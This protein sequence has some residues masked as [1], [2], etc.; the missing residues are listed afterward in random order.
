MTAI[1][2][3]KNLARDFKNIAIAHIKKNAYR[4]Y[5]LC[6]S[7]LIEEINKKV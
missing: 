4:I 1:I 7:K 3:L 2:F 5:F 6:M